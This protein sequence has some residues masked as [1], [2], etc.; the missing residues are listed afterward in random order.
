M[1]RNRETEVAAVALLSY[2]HA[3]QHEGEQTTITCFFLPICRN[4]MQY[5]LKTANKVSK[6]KP[7]FSHDGFGIAILH[8]MVPQR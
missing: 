7:N 5:Y 3:A 8:V 1:G 4:F 6:T 2:S